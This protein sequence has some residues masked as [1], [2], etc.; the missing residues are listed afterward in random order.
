[1]KKVS[2]NPNI[3]IIEEPF[4][5][6]LALRLSRIS[7]LTMQKALHQRYLHV[8]T[9]IFAESHREKIREYIKLQNDNSTK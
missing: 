3:T 2:I 1:M 9:P 7:D 6:V 4:E 5:L 8:L